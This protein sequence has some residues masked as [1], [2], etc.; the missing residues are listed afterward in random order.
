MNSIKK[1][2]K[3]ISNKDKKIDP[4]I[5]VFYKKLGISITPTNVSI[6]HA[7]YDDSKI[8]FT[9]YTGV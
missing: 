3:K 8:T 5:K 9:S 6:E 2:D 7:F 4:E 1:I